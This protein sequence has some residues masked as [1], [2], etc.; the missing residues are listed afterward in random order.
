MPV[1]TAADLREFVSNM[2]IYLFDQVI[3]GRLAPGMAVLDV[4]C[5]GGRNIRWLLQADFEVWAVD[6]KAATIDKARTLAQ[7]VDPT[8]S[9]D[10]FQVAELQSLPFEDAHFLTGFGHSDGTDGPGC[11][12]GQ[13]RSSVDVHHRRQ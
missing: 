12:G 9:A 1:P 2:D 4:G 8:I 13:R 7:E 10:R 6:K 11:S 3:K 5:G